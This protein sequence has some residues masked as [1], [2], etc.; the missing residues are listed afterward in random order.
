MTTMFK[1]LRYF[2]L[3]SA[4]IMALMTTLLVWS[5]RSTELQR[6]VASAE[7][8]NV[9]LARTIANTTGDSIGNYVSLVQDIPPEKLRTMAETQQWHDAL[10]KIVSGLPI[11]KLKFYTIDG[12][13][14]YSSEPE[15]IGSATSRPEDLAAAISASRA[16]SRFAFQDRFVAFDAVLQRSKPV[17]ARPAAISYGAS[18][19]L[20]PYGERPYTPAVAPGRP[21]G[22]S[23]WQIARSA[24]PMM[25][26]TGANIGAKS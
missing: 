8:E 9:S 24:A 23:M 26:A 10:H 3:C 25:G 4:V 21:T 11:L 22:I 15:Q 1:L 18:S 13:T 5:F 20:P 14:I 7:A 6:L 19:R 12:R 2:S 17:V 16:I